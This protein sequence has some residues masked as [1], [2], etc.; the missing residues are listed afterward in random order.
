[1]NILNR[2]IKSW[3]FRYTLS[4]LMFFVALAACFAAFLVADDGKAVLMFLVLGL[5]IAALF[6]SVYFLMTA[7]RY[8]YR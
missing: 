5:E 8:E 4:M 1:M 2:I 7:C 6:S 3:G